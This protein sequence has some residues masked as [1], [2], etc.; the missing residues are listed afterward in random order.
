MGELVTPLLWFYTWSSLRPVAIIPI[1]SPWAKYWDYAHLVWDDYRVSQSVSSLIA[2]RLYTHIRTRPCL[3]V[4]TIPAR[5]NARKCLS[6]VGNVIRNG[7]TSFE[8]DIAPP[9]CRRASM[10][11]RSGSPRAFSIRLAFFCESPRVYVRRCSCRTLALSAARFS[12]LIL[13]CR[14]LANRLGFQYLVIGL[15]IG[16][17]GNGVNA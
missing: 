16:M 6:A 11:R 12:I 3:C 2:S 15:S 8:S 13:R 5:S 7:S 9:P 14:I 17:E 1:L 4:V 10:L